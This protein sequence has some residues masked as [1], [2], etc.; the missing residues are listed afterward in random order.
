[1]DQ[2]ASLTCTFGQVLVADL[3][4]LAPEDTPLV[5]DT[6]A[7]CISVAVIHGTEKLATAV[8]CGV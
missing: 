4:Q 6:L 7:R 3:A 1:M 2:L 5:P 8:P